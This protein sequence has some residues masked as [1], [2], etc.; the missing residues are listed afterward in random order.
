MSRPSPLHILDEEH[1][2]AAH[3]RVCPD[4]L[5][6]PG[7]VKRGLN[8]VELPGVGCAK[9]AFTLVE[10]LVVIG[11]I[12]VLIAILLPALSGA[13]SQGY[14]VSCMS[15]LRQVGQAILLY[16]NDN[17]GSF[18]RTWYYVGLY[19]N[20]P[21]DTFAGLRGFSDPVAT[22]PF[23]NASNPTGDDVLPPWQVSKR[24]GD[25]DVT[26]CIFLLL[27]TYN[28]PAA[29]FVCPAR[30]DMY[31]DTFS[32]MGIAG[33]SSDP[34]RRSNF[35]SPYNLSYSISL[36][37]PPANG[38]GIGYRWNS[39]A[40]AGFAIMADLNPG[41][42][43]P[44]CCV[45]THSGLYGGNG[46]TTPSDPANIQA[47]AN[48]RNHNK[49]GQNV[50]YADGHC[51]WAPTA[52]AGYNQDNIYTYAG[53]IGVTSGITNQWTT[54]SQLPFPWT[55]LQPNDSIMQPNEGDMINPTNGGIGIN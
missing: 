43:F 41:E 23:A 7:P 29:L 10:L 5:P 34:T 22:D 47:M 28:L 16:A 33:A 55:M 12:A 50:L 32:T 6:L 27:R 53:S 39:T 18:P 4:A 14:R 15:N 19:Y 42:R 52:F 20:N 24:P 36:P 35:S 38:W 17:K 25:N 2:L 46:P 21:T 26:A 37:F 1:S 9:R 13:R 44:D 54:G 48:S 31:P 30:Y 51:E 8:L 45:V 49:K 40:N 11:I 3:A